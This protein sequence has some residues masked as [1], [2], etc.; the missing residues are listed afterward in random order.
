MTE[1]ADLVQHSEGTTDRSSYAVRNPWEVK[2]VFLNG[3]NEKSTKI[4]Q[5]M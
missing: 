1:R 5:T 4:R 3:Y 2:P